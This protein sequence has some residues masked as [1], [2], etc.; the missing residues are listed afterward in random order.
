L[1]FFGVFLYAIGFI[2]NLFV[3]NSLDSEPRSPAGIAFAVD[4]LLLGLFAIQHSVM[5]RPFFKRWIKE[6]IPE[7]AERSTYVMTTNAAMIALFFLWQPIGS[8]IWDITLPFARWVVYAV[9]F[10]GW[11]LVFVATC[12][13]SHFD[14]FGLRQGWYYFRGKPCPQ[15]NFVMP[16]LY[17]YV[18]HP[19][20]IGWL[21]VFWAA[22]T[23]TVGHLL[24]SMLTSAYILVAVQFEE[25]DL[26]AAH[27]PDYAN[28]R[29]QV[30]MFIPRWRRISLPAAQQHST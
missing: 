29:K 18:R 13:I 12:L 19:L 30:P 25:R 21:M 8:T 17:K 4:A 9:F 27:G 11:A 26:V 5:A 28:Y 22:P 10:A 7:A 1:V 2:G 6:H 14:L 24:F 20:Y 23:M 15:L 3:P 16:A